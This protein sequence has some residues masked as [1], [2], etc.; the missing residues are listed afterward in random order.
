MNVNN[1]GLVSSYRPLIRAL[2]KASKRSH[3]EQ[4]KQDIKKEITVLTYKKIQTVREQA[5][6]KDSNEKL[7]LLK[8]SHSLSKQIEDL[9]S[10]DPSKSK[11]LFFY[12]HSKEL[13]SIIMSDP[14]S[15]GVFEKRLEHLMDVAAFV[16][17][18]MEYDILIDRYNPGLGMSQEEK[19]RRTANKVGLQVPEDVL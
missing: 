10:Q 8:L 3:I 19:V 2:V 9:K 13:R 16:K 18:Q 17:N 15:R 1:S 7:N 6:M 14:V 11:K 12:P 4:I 5:D